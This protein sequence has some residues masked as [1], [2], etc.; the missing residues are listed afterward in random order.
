[1]QDFIVSGKIIGDR[2][3]AEHKL[4]AGDHCLLPVEFP[5]LT[6]A[7]RRAAGVRSALDPAGITSEVI[8]TGTVD[9]E[10]QNIISQAILANPK[11]SCIIGLGTT[12]ANLAPD[13][14]AE[15]GRESLPNGGLDTHPTD[16]PN[17][18]HR[19]T[20]RTIDPP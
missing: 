2:M 20:T 10:A 11:I 4:K 6:Y 7:V 12:P 9:A 17:N 13:A 16:N 15:A 5:E 14:A 8:G 18:N 3:I 1:G 19:Q